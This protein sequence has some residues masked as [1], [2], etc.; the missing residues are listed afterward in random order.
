MNIY[1]K[2]QLSRI[3]LQ[4]MGLKKS[5]KNKFAGFAYYELSDFMPK[6]NEIF[7]ELKLYSMFTVTENEAILEIINAE[8]PEEK[9]VFKSPTAKVEMKGCTPIQGIGAVHTY[10]KRYLYL[11]ALEIVEF[12]TL[13]AS[14]GTIEKANPIDYDKTIE[15]VSDIKQLNSTYKWLK[16]NA[17][18]DSWKVS[19]NKKANTLNAVFNKEIHRFSPY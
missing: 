18:N 10:M 16:E 11:N 13:D 8:S 14:A 7:C 17:D 19:L 2:L 6:I 9:V 4:S 5:G 3:K 15:S 1:E 12:D